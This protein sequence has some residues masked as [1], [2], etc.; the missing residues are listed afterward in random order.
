MPSCAY[1]IASRLF[2]ASCGPASAPQ[3]A[4]A[5]TVAQSTSHARGEIC[6]R[7][8]P[9]P[10]RP[11][12]LVGMAALLQPH[13]QQA[14]ELLKSFRSEQRSVLR[15]KA[16]CRHGCQRLRHLVA[17]LAD[18]ADEVRMLLKREQMA[19]A[20]WK[21]RRP[22]SFLNTDRNLLPARLPQG[23]PDTKSD[24]AD[25]EGQFPASRDLARALGG[26]ARAAL[27]LLGQEQAG[28]EG[29]HD[30]EDAANN[31]LDAAKSLVLNID[32]WLLGS[33][34]AVARPRLGAG[35]GAPVSAVGCRHDCTHAPAPALLMLS[36]GAEL[37]CHGAGIPRTGPGAAR[38]RGVHPVTGW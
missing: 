35:S 14:N 8:P 5:E 21:S 28:R 6:N 1:R 27:A 29:G 24:A 2:H 19:P 17:E 9:A 26:A 34:G 23:A 12:R 18:V 3:I 10:R 38:Q 16:L 7:R 20:G 33:S 37:Y 25:D 32:R 31:A 36:K 11:E 4:E 13:L 30:S 22:G 15:N